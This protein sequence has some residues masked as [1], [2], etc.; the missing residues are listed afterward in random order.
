MTRTWW[1]QY[2]CATRPE[3]QKQ[4]CG[5]VVQSGEIFE[6]ALKEGSRCRRCSSPDLG[7]QLKEF[8]ALFAGE[9]DK[10]V[11]SVS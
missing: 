8:A 11:S 5:S 2:I 4:P 3:L 10:A 7:G 1:R 9:I 6:R